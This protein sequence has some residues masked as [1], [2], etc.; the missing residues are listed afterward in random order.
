M[1][2]INNL[3]KTIVWTIMI[4]PLI[5]LIVAVMIPV[6]VYRSDSEFWGLIMTANIITDTKIAE[7]Y[8]KLL[9]FIGYRFLGL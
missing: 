5:L 3:I 9:R 4:V 2:N 1:K 6:F 8:L 7:V